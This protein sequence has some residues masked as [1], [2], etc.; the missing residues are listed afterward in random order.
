MTKFVYWFSSSQES[1]GRSFSRRFCFSLSGHGSFDTNRMSFEPSAR[2]SL[3][4]S[5]STS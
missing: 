3:T 1:I 4:E 2:M 5:V